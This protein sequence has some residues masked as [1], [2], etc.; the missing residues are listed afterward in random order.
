MSIPEVEAA[1]D[2]LARHLKEVYDAWGVD[3]SGRRAKIIVDAMRAEGWRVPLP[4]DSR[5]PPVRVPAADPH[6]RSLMAADA[7]E[8]VRSA[9][10]QMRYTA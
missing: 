5:P 1:W 9:K 6:F 3:E 4:R 10:R 7:R 8:A 2:A